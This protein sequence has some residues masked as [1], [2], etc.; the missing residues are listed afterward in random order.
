MVCY[1]MQLLVLVLVFTAGVAACSGHVLRQHVGSVRSA[2]S[3]AD[4]AS[5]ELRGTVI[6]F[7]F[8]LQRSL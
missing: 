2:S 3:V 7:V 5:E 4:L 1:Q 6:S 8:R